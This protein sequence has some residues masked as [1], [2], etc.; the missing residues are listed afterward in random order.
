[1]R[2]P[3]IVPIYGVDRHD[4]RLGFWSDFVKGLTL[5][6][7][8][9]RQGATGP[10]EAALIGI[11]VCRAAGAVHA[12]GFLHR[13]IKAGN[14][15]REEGGRILLMDFG[16]THE[17]GSGGD[18]SGTPA[19][20]APELLLGQPATIATDIYAIGVMLFYLLTKQYP[21]QGAGVAALRAAHAA[22]ERLRLLDA[23]PDLPEP[24][25]RVVETAI[26]ET[27]AQRFG[28]TGQMI[29][30]L[31]EAIGLGSS[32]SSLPAPAAVKPRRFRSWLLAPVLLAVVVLLILLGRQ[33][34]LPRPDPPAPV[35]G[36]QE[37]YRRAHDLL[38]HYYRPQALETAIPLLEKVVA[39]DAQFAPAFAD[40]GRANFL[41]FAQQR[42]TKYLEPAREASLRALA[43]APDLVSAH[44]TLGFLYAFTDQNDLAGHELET[45]LRLDKLNAAAYGA[46]AELQTRQGH[47]EQAEATLQTGISLAPYDW[48]LN[49]Q[50]G[51]HYLDGGKWAQAGDQFRH[52]IELA[53]D[54]PRAHNNLGLVYRGLG[55]LDEAAASFQQAIDLEP[56]FLHF[57]NLGMV[58]AETAKY[59][60]AEQAVGRSIEL[61]PNQYRA[62]G[63][64]ASI[65]ANQHAD[66]AKVRDTYLKAIAL[67]S[68]LLKETRR[69]NTSWPTS[70]ATTRRWG[71]RRRA[72]RC[73]R[74]RRRWDRTFP[75]SCTRW[76]SGT[77][78]CT[79]ATRRCDGLRKAEPAAILPKRLRAIRCYPRSAR[80]RGTV[81]SPAQA[82]DQ[83][84]TQEEMRCPIP[85]SIVRPRRRRNPRRRRPRHGRESIR[86]T[87]VHNCLESHDQHRDW[88]LQKAKRLGLVARKEKIP[89]ARD[90][91]QDWWNIG[92]QKSTGSCV[93]WAL[94]DSVLRY[95]FVKSGKLRKH[96][97]I[98][99][100]YIWMAA[101]EM[102][103]KCEYPTTF[104]DDAGTSAKSALRVVKKI[105]VLKTSALPF[106]GGL[107]TLKEKHFLKVAGRLKVK[108]YFN[109]CRAQR[110][111]L[112]RF[113]EWLAFHGPI[114]TR[115]RVDP[116][117][118]NIGADGQ[119]RTYDKA[120][121]NGGHAVSI[122][123]YTPKHFII[124]NSWEPR[125]GSQGICLRELRVHAGRLPRGVR[126]V[127]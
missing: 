2:H 57:R 50:L 62:W 96:E 68:D 77:S 118:N 67:A 1:V 80:I 19:Y 6:D 55:K 20:M 100:R 75:R 89:A 72:C 27:P 66:P 24:L 48:L 3:N 59:A 78:C 71:T 14:V 13:D 33:A 16:L 111:K 17:H 22:G 83:V 117:W 32:S 41:Q 106:K 26:S 63:L 107:V 87:R 92:N 21:V 49:M 28:S 39:Q 52:A 81:R 121:A 53:P 126:I 31:S 115:L 104:L 125:L 64:L 54:N 85:T 9:I 25:A 88:S 123:G 124:R 105:G 18:A 127:I 84:Q 97:H 69:T 51:A 82:A 40:L 112:D 113:K 98:S 45:A 36:V 46:L 43:L 109:L 99:V 65:Y 5:S 94:A 102:D 8:V 90:L 114:L 38:T 4:E 10:R 70:A 47:P 34:L 79:G 116:S 12:A 44:V 120:R 15:M 91:R 103:H 42:D 108:A 73:S 74:K 37:D 35:A 76:P 110:G 122:V 61:R 7:L 23:R 29:A 86:G 93:G 58:L 101:K 95:H 119:L 30:A 56:T 11:E 60:E